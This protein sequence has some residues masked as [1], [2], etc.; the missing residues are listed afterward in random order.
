MSGFTVRAGLEPWPQGIDRRLAFFAMI[1]ECNTNL[2]KQMR[3][4]EPPTAQADPAETV[5]G[6]R[7]T[8][9][10]IRKNSSRNDIATP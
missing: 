3:F 10:N 6:F 1:V 5:S 7:P 4:E 9:T 8:K 2:C